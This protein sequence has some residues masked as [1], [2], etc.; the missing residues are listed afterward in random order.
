M[1]PAAVI[2][3]AYLLGSI[4]FSYLV[5]RLFAGADIRQHGSRNVG[6]TNVARSFGKVPGVIALLLDIAKGYAA[7]EVARWIVFRPEWPI[8]TSMS[9]GPLQLEE[10]CI[11]L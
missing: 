2:V 7:V 11:A 1:L 9:G 4:P 6:A 10:L 8:A 3:S 5:V